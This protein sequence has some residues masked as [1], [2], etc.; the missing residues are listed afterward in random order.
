MSRPS[1]ARLV[2]LNVRA[3]NRLFWRVP[4]GAFFTLALP[5]I[6]LVLFVALFGNDPEDSALGPVTPAQFYTPALAVFSV[7]SATFTNIAINLST[8]REEGILRRVRG[9]PLP[10]WIYIAGAI[11]SAVWIGVIALAVMVGLGVV[12]YDVN[13]EL[14]KLPAM[15]LTFVVGSIAF[16]MLGVALAGVAKSASSASALANATILPMA[17]VSDIF[18]NLGGDPPEW[19]RILGDLLP[20]RH[21]GIAFSEAMS[22]FSDAPAIVW[23]R[24][25]VLAAWAVVGALLARWRFR[26]DPVTGSTGR[27][28][29]RSGRR[30]SV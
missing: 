18:I 15:G 28:S 27:S 22:P 9:T 16:A 29:R 3:Q 6:M 26:W 17:F 19:L 11:G 30:S 8:R 24:L 25:G 7:G 10:P 12:A 4:I 23:D 2:L 14:A 1:T 5:V 21:F 20:L 13:I